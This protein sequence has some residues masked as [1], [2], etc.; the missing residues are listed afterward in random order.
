MPILLF[1][2][3]MIMNV[4]AFDVLRKEDMHLRRGKEDPY[5]V[6][7]M[8][9]DNGITD[10]SS[11]I[12]YLSYKDNKYDI[13]LVFLLTEMQTKKCIICVWSRIKL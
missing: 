13:E 5:N 7:L 11:R 6:H 10:F 9:R 8:D 3:S 2:I 4:S 12:E 1:N